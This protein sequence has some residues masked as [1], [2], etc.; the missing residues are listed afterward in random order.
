MQDLT[1]G[2]IP[3][4]IIKMSSFMLITMVFQTLYFLVDL[5]FVGRLGKEAV[6][7]VGVAGNLMFIVL[8]LS[9]MLGVGTTALVSHAVGA[10]DKTRALLVFNQSQVMAAIVGLLFLI[11]G[12]ALMG[13]YSRMLAA[14]AQTARLA[15]SYLYWFMP[16]MALQFA[17]V[18]TGAALRGVGNFRP[19]MI[20]STA[21]VIINMVLAP[22]LIFGWGTGLAMGIAGAALASFIAVSIGV[23][24]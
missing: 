10:R 14:D 3:R 9:Q 7:A 5:Y 24:G 12:L 11:A 21:T 20:V 1:Q 17:M 4:N 6:A 18:A 16:A 15:E 22:F 13:V 19:G 23:V 2:S 8:A